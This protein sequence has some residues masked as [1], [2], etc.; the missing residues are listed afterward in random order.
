MKTKYRYLILI[1]L[2][3]FPSFHIHAQAWRD[4]MK[5][6]IYTPR[7]F[8]PN[9]FPIPELRNGKAASRYEV[10]ARGEYHYFD[11]DK[12]K[13]LYTR[14]QLPLVKGRAG[15]EVSI[16]LYEEYKMTAEVVEERHA[17]APESPIVCH[18]DVIVS[19][20]FQL[21]KNPKWLDALVTINLKTASGGRVCDARYTD[22]VTYWFDLNVGR[23][24]YES[25]NRQFSL[26]LQ[27]L[28]GFYCW[29]TNDLVH[30]QNDAISY[31]AGLSAVYRNLSL[32]SDFGGFY[33]YK[34]NGDNP[35]VLRNNLRFEYKKN[36]LS[37]R[38]HLGIK[39]NL[40]DSV[41]LGY[42]RCF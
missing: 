30:R 28:A 32:D 18:G 37:L 9:A 42:I 29:M 36:I 8:G 26:R 38:Y 19:S 33:G 39:D 5:E 16:R 27:A 14:V 25:P 7:Y 15:V 10:E 6:L 21:L 2:L 41:S 17:V 22:A 3:T 23:N 31:G 20:F 34:S 4:K 40:Y 11:G 35:M 24:L 1:A 13:N 12:T